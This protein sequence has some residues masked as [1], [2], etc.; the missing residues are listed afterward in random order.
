LSVFNKF[1]SAQR[2]N[3]NSLKKSKTKTSLLFVSLK[4]RIELKD[5]NEFVGL[6]VRVRVRGPLPQRGKGPVGFVG[7]RPNGV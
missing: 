5:K 7:L 3:V 4:T 2:G 6:G 1:F